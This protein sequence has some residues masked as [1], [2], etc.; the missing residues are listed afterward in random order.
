MTLLAEF[1]EDVDIFK[2][3]GIPASVEILAWG[4]KQITEPLRG[5]VVEIRIDATCK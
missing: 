3:V 5:K 2:P 1:N 4:M